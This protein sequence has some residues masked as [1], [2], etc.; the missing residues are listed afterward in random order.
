MDIVLGLS[1]TATT[2]RVVLVEGER[3]DGVTIENAAFD[4]E[5]PDGAAKPSPSEQVSNAI[6]ATQQNALST[7]HHLVVS[8]VTWE[9]EAQQG[10]LRDSMIARGLDNVM[11]M[12][13]QSAAAALAQTIGRALGYDAT[14]VLLMKSDTATLS[15]VNSAD[16]SIAEVLT[17]NVAAAK[18][19]DALPEI[20]TSLETNDPHP[21]GMVIVGSCVELAAVK[22]TLES[23][24]AVPVI[25]PEEPDLTLARGAALAAANAA[26]L[27]APTVG[28][29]YSQDPDAQ[30][31]KLSDADTEISPA[32]DLGAE[33]DL[34]SV[35][36]RT[37]RALLIPVGSFVGTLFVLGVVAVVMSLAVSI[38]STSDDQGLPAAQNALGP[39]VMVP[40]PP[41]VASPT[42][43]PTMVHSP[44]SVPQAQLLQPPPAPASPEPVAIAPEPPVAAPVNTQ[45]PKP[46][47]TAPVVQQPAPSRV[48]TE[49]T[50]VAAEQP[51]NPVPAAIEPPPAQAAPVPAPVAAPP[52]VALPPPA[53]AAPVAPAQQPPA[54]IFPW[55]P[56]TLRI[57]PFRI[58]LGPSQPP[59]PPPQQ[60]S[61]GPPIAPW[62]PQQAPPPPA[63]S[64]PQAPL[65]VT[66]SPPLQ[67][68]PRW[69]NPPASPPVAQSP[70]QSPAWSPSQAPPPVLGGRDG[71]H[72]RW[73][74]WG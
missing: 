14:A 22:S 57:G 12:S 25:V 41:A 19:A 17:R 28:L 8:G 30:G 63:W 72:E 45:A 24:V 51:L 53:A 65:P 15:I 11:L 7:G 59:A 9:D 48:L 26:G 69:W 5:A 49:P 33:D 64:P 18:L 6:L 10:A 32:I 35:V 31:V 36:A 3:A 74:P 61:A 40:T 62:A 2:V 55:G 66:E 43:V 29:A 71:G 4:T 60:V 1:M 73:W 50:P 13:E 58:P 68:T 27:E 70:P 20:V 23:L 44:P 47:A 38:R 34:D 67:Q 54:P 42:M 21:Q 16:G 52:P 39:S 46:R 37:G 56:P